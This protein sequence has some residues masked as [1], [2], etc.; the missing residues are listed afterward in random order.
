MTFARRT[1]R[2]RMYSYVGMPVQPSAWLC[3]VC[4]LFVCS[5][6][7]S[8][9]WPVR[10]LGPWQTRVSVQSRLYRCAIRFQGMPDKCI[11]AQL[12]IF[13]HIKT[14]MCAHAS[15]YASFS[16]STMSIEARVFMCMQIEPWSAASHCAAGWAHEAA[17]RYLRAQDSYCTAL[18]LD[19]HHPTALLRQGAWAARMHGTQCCVRLRLCVG[20][21]GARVRVLWD[22]FVDAQVCWCARL[23]RSRSCLLGVT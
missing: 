23:G 5:C 22:P 10:D 4:L 16:L 1:T 14:G 8:W 17:G 18:S 11:H 3:V 21:Q 2:M 12:H 13:M 6:G 19:P 15:H 7:K 9:P 20:L